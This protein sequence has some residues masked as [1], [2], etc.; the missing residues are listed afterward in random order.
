MGRE[1]ERIVVTRIEYLPLVADLRQRHR[2]LK[3]LNRMGVRSIEDIDELTDDYL[4]RERNLARRSV[5]QIRDAIKRWKE[6]P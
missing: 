6:E 2:I 4:L 3:A 1:R 5:H